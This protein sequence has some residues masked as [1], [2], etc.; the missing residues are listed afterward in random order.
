MRQWIKQA[1][2][3]IS[4]GISD[5]AKTLESFRRP[6]RIIAAGLAV[7]ASAAVAVTLVVSLYDF[8]R[9]PP[10]KTASSLQTDPTAPAETEKTPN[11]QKSNGQANQNDNLP[12]APIVRVVVAS[13]YVRETTAPLNGNSR[14]V[15][16]ETSQ[17]VHAETSNTNAASVAPRSALAAQNSAPVEVAKEQS[18]PVVET[19]P[20]P[21]EELSQ[22]APE[23]TGLRESRIASAVNL[24]ARPHNHAD[25]LTVIPTDA[26]IMAQANCEHWCNVVYD[27]QQGYIYK[28]FIRR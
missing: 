7:T 22:E 1:I 13:P 10:Q 15:P 14:N 5:P 12:P 19:S 20:V 26:V 4:G 24:R 9:P 16:T 2:S 11:E 21:S 6:L 3:R 17:S 18:Q 28:T 23:E 8:N 25:V 27:G